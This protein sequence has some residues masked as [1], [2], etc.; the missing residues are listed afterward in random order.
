MLDELIPGTYTQFPV[1]KMTKLFDKDFHSMKNKKELDAG[2]RDLDYIG[3]TTWDGQKN[4]RYEALKKAAIEV[5]RG[6]LINMN[7]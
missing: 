1:H 4:K 2:M 6:N 3:E 5:D 7:V